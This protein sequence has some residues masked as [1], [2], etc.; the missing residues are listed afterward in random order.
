[1]SR[2]REMASKPDKGKVGVW[3]VRGNKA[4]EQ[5]VRF[6]IMISICYIRLLSL[7]SHCWE[8]GI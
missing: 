2:F 5:L 7:T 1:M 4:G 6:D 8:T 3:S